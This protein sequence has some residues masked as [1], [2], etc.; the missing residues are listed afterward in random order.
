MIDAERVRQVLVEEAGSQVATPAACS[1][2]QALLEAY[3]PRETE[4]SALALRMEDVVFECLY[5]ALGRQMLT[6]LD[7]GEV[8][9][10]RMDDLPE[11]ADRMLTPLL[12]SLEVSAA[13][14]AML[15]RHAMETGSVS[16]MAVLYRRYAAYQSED[17]QA[18][19][20]RVL[21]DRYPQGRAPEWLRRPG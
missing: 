2:V 6:V 1:R 21:R 10:F 19:L 4:L 9:R 11:L 14:Y 5:S 20:G 8:R 3:V 16:A 13:N 12:E 17:E 7:S 15:R 18:V